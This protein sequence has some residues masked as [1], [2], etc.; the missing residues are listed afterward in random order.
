MSE[1]LIG[2]LVGIVGMIIFIVLTALR[3]VIR[4]GKGG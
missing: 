3:Y 1:F 4:G 2:V